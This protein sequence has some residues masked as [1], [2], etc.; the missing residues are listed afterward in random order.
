VEK[1]SVLNT[2]DLHKVILHNFAQH[3]IRNMVFS[4]EFIAT[5]ICV[6]CRIILGQPQPK[7]FLFAIF[8]VLENT[9][10]HTY[11]FAKFE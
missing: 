4:T 1:L 9:Y 3:G 5:F 7:R 10:L 8:G 2:F 6:D 11:L